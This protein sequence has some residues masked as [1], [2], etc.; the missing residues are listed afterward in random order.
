MAKPEVRLD[1]KVQAKLLEQ[2][3]EEQAA[4]ARGSL[5]RKLVLLPV[6]LG[7]TMGLGSMVLSPDKTTA[8]LG[9]VLLSTVL[10]ALWKSR[11]RIGALFD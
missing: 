3:R 9:S 4:R 11:K 1:P 8:A 7:M 6:L 2:M 10:F 5:V